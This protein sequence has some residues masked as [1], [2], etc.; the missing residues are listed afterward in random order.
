VDLHA[1]ADDLLDGIDTAAA[2]KA[3]KDAKAKALASIK[4]GPKGRLHRGF[5]PGV[6]T[7]NRPDPP[8]A[9]R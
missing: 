4:V 8:A 3:D 7:G 1:A 5:N 2:A 6:S 9:A